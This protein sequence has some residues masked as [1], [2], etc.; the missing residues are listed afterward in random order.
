LTIEEQALL[1][2]I[3]E[4]PDGVDLLIHVSAA[5]AKRGLSYTLVV[6]NSVF[7]VQRPVGD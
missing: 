3:V 1:S 5:R 7:D 6:A 2:S 4:T